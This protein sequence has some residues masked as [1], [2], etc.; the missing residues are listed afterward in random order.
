MTSD[1]T[2]REGSGMLFDEIMQM[3]RYTSVAGSLF[4]SSL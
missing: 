2:E 3:L 4:F 1:G